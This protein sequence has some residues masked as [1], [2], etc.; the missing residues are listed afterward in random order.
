MVLSYARDVR[1][2]TN[3]G[4]AHK[5]GLITPS[6]TRHRASVHDLPATRIVSGF[7]EAGVTAEGACITH[8]LL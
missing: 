3:S 4:L 7:N 1:I 2:K 8:E 5:L 6:S